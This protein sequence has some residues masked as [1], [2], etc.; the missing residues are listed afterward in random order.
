[1]RI[2]ASSSTW[3]IPSNTYQTSP[4]MLGLTRLSSGKNELASV[5]GLGEHT[6][7]KNGQEF[8]P[9]LCE[10]PDWD[11]RQSWEPPMC[12][13]TQGN[14][15]WSVLCCID[16][17]YNNHKIWISAYMNICIRLHVEQ[18][19]R[20][21][22]LATSCMSL[23]MIVGA[24][25]KHNIGPVRCNPLVATKFAYKFLMSFYIY[26]ILAQLTGPKWGWDPPWGLGQSR[27]WCGCPPFCVRHWFPSQSFTVNL[28]PAYFLGS[29]SRSWSRRTFGT[30]GA[31]LFARGPCWWSYWAWLPN[32]SLANF[33][34]RSK[35]GLLDPC[36]WSSFDSS[37][38]FWSVLFSRMQ[39]SWHVNYPDHHL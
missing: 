34:N 21:T 28:V 27:S 30:D 8:L 37:L 7:K 14:R 4:C 16:E 31:D 3:P 26:A 17:A 32:L 23:N 10:R 19:D 15:K 38:A 18:R 9:H 11:G 33:F 6:F 25:D 1:M 13:I 35:A 29:W 36:G 12:S 24:T 20:W 5:L 39:L 22:F 2:L